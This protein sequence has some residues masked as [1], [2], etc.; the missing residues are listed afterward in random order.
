M[1]THFS[2]VFRA[3]F[4][5]QSVPILKKNFTLSYT[6]YNSNNFAFKGCLNSPGFK[7]VHFIKY[8]TG[9]KPK[10]ANSEFQRLLLLAK[11]ERF[12]LAGNI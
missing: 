2:Q 1:W 4:V 6:L 5:L 8:S 11:S 12:R 3:R 9:V 10:S 7:Q